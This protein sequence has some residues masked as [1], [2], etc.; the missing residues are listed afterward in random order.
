MPTETINLWLGVGTI[1]LQVLTVAF[2]ALYF[3]RRSVPDLEDIASILRRWG[4][5]LALALSFLGAFLTLF[6]SY[7]LNIPPCDLCWWQRIAL[8]PQIILFAFAWK[9]LEKWIPLYSMTLSVIG[10]GIALYNHALQMFPA[11]ALPCPSQGV[12]CAQ[13][14]FL[15]FGYITYPMM[16]LT[17]FAFLFVLMLFV[18]E[19][20]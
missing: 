9:R 19:R 8:Y 13:I 11:G 5:P 4:I 10:A 16:S 12:S 3:L 1:V 2:F 6:Y 14:F 20:A 7:V 18:R 17:L 15:E